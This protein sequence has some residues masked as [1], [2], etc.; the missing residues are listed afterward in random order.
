[1][2]VIVMVHTVLRNRNFTHKIFRIQPLN[3]A[4]LSEGS[5]EAGQPEQAAERGLRPGRA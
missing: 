4:R 2:G 3:F 5:A 1:M